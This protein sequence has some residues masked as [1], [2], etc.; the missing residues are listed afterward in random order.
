[1]ARHAAAIVGMLFLAHAAAAQF[2]QQGGKLVGT[3][4]VDPANQGGAVAI[5]ADGN[6]AIVGGYSYD[7][8]AGAAWVYTRSGGVWSQQGTK[9]VGMGAVG[10]AWQG[11]SRNPI[12]R[13]VQIKIGGVLRK[14]QE[15]RPRHLGLPIRASNHELRGTE[16]EC[17]RIGQ[18]PIIVNGLRYNPILGNRHENED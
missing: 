12:V 3:G 5:S 4:A 13:K 14:P 16:L 9:L 18:H 2:A 15:P 10:A 8:N 6:T 7:S 1:M 11:I 17:L